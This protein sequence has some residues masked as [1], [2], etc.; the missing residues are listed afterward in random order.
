MPILDQIWHKIWNLTLTFDLEMTLSLISHWPAKRY[1]IYLIIDEIWPKYIENIS[2][3]RWNNANFG[4]KWC[5]SQNLTLTF[6]LEMT[7]R[8]NFHW[9]ANRYYIYL[10]IDEIWPKYI[11]NISFSGWNKA[12]F[13]LKMIKIQIF[14][15]DLWPW[16]D[17]DRV[18]ILQSVYPTANNSFWKYYYKRPW[19]K[20]MRP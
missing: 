1:Y 13:G 14:D 7:L 8:L 12:N 15:L 4:Q 9:S 10:A 2:F 3:S 19:I 11:E 20:V 18:F 6:D 16:N 5:K 17:L